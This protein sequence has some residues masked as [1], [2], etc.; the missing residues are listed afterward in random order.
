VSRLG[1]P[2]VNELLIPLASKD[3]FNS[4]PPVKDSQFA[5]SFSN[6]GLAQLLPSLYAG[7]FP[8]LGT[9]NA[10]T[11]NRADISAILTTGIPVGL[12][13]EVPTYTTAPNA[14]KGTSAQS[15][16]LRLNM[17]IP[18]TT[19]GPNNLGLLGGDVAGFP[20]GRRVFDDVATIELRAVAGATLG[21]VDPNFTPD[22]AAGPPFATSGYVSF[23]LTHSQTDL[24]ASGAGNVPT[25]FYLQSFPYLAT[26]H[27]GFAADT[28]VA[29]TGG[30]QTNGTASG[31]LAASGD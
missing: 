28:A 16:M 20:N 19:D 15:D 21:L 24:Q 30:S 2:L 5:A 8:H 12:I 29:A 1:N 17:A 3:L 27:S 14:G 31:P 9:Y 11:V 22:T 4:E 23:G 26:P 25:E 10:G 7:V 13:T 18:P 6:P